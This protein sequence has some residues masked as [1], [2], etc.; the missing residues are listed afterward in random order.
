[1][2]GKKEDMFSST[3]FL[4]VLE[5][6]ANTLTFAKLEIANALQLGGQ[7]LAFIL[8][9]IEYLHDIGNY[10]LF[11]AT[12]DTLT[13][14]LSV[15]NAFATPGLAYSEIVDFNMLTRVDVG[16]AASGGWRDAPNI[17]D[18]SQYPG[19]GLILP[20]DR[21]YIFLAGTSLTGAARVYARIHYTTQELSADQYWQLVEQ[22]H[23][24]TT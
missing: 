10:A 23:L 13:F 19:G 1:M 22:R 4:S 20:A 7:K 16:A 6:A 11:N 12:A 24:L 5:S 15:S 8:H 9:A 2:A 14:G 18:F 3:A 21:L 17:K